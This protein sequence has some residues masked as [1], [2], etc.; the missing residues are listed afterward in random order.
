MAIWA[1]KSSIFFFKCLELSQFDLRMRYRVDWIFTDCR[2]I[3]VTCIW[4]KWSCTV[5]RC[6]CCC[7]NIFIFIQCQLRFEN[8]FW[9]FSNHIF[10]FLHLLLL[11]LL[12]GNLVEWISHWRADF[13]S[14]LSVGQT[15]SF[16]WQNL[17][18]FIIKFGLCGWWS[19]W[20]MLPP[21]L[22]KLNHLLLV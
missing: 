8:H 20:D 17:I 18:R 9:Y 11:I 16:R 22:R 5:V 14:T 6:R 2:L 19:S 1:E 7:M 3:V 13:E 10:T 4:H 12:L 15:L 21:M